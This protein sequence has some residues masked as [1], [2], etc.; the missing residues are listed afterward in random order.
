MIEAVNMCKLGE[1][2]CWTA[3]TEGSDDFSVEKN[4]KMELGRME[5]VRTRS[6]EVSFDV[7][8]FCWLISKCH[9]RDSCLSFCFDSQGGRVGGWEGVG[10]TEA[11]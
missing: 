6:W 4:K 10:R 2:H 1:E 8:T 3:V 11:Y 5:C 7:D 9:K